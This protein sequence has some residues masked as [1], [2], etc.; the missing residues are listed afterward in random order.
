[1]FDTLPKTVRE[2]MDW[3]WAQIEPYF[4]DLEV[5][6]LDADM[7]NDWLADWTHISAFLNESYSR[8]YVATTVNTADETA[9]QR[10]KDFLETT[11]PVW[12]SAE[13]RLKEKFLASGLEPEGFAIPRRNM[14]T[15]AEIFRQENLPLITE[16]EKLSMEFN[17][18]L[19]AQ[20]ISWEGKELTIA[21][22]RPI[23]LNSD[24]AVREKAW[25]LAIERQMQ[26]RDTINGLWGKFLDV[27]RK[28]AANAGFG[29]DYRAFRWKEFMRFDYTPENCKQF[30]AA[31]EQ[32]VVPAAV[33]LYEK[34][35]K[36]LGYDSLRPWDVDVDPLSRQPLR[37][38]EGVRELERKSEAMF[39]LV[40]PQLGDYF[41]IMRREALLDL[42]NRRDKAPGGYC[43]NFDV[44][45]RPFIFM[46]AVGIHDDVQTMMHEAGHAFHVFE[47]AKLPYLQQL[48]T[49]IEFA[50]V[51][52]MS[53]ELL[54]APYL[55]DG[56]V[57]FYREPEAIRAR[58]EH[59]EE[60][61][62]FWPYMA[63]VD[64]FQHWVYENPDAA[65]NPAN[66][67]SKWAELWGRFMQGVDWSGLDEE[68]K[69][70]W[71]R[72]LHIHRIPLYYVEYGL[73]QLGAVQVW[74]NSLK[75]QSQAVADY[76]KALALGGTVG[77]PEL[78]ATAG[79]KFAFDAETL[80]IAVELIEKTLEQLDGA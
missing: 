8:L 77:L 68:M 30:H 64:A 67:D 28:M 32:V 76:R 6:P 66:C 53:M 75:N 54:A 70:G 79:A 33:R 36:H 10:L 29:D 3:S 20:T 47:S 63:V 17:R 34:R 15:A 37:P 9:E 14:Q 26:D 2:F 49:P 50:E 80:G 25:R 74:R 60:L 18:I 73:A 22:V 19:G 51:A 39:Y 16:E 4:Q 31:I 43:T 56:E 11:H 62:T 35:R 7:V 57:R 42:E 21:Q 40:D 48:E 46:N 78:F 69:T 58:V 61:I 1:M 59:L 72:K 12:K 45:R 44:I 52:S 41:D 13:Q 23:Y 24:R 38:F 55:A 65:A 27:R 71:H 5:R